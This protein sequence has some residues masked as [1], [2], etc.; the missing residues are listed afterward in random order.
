MGVNILLHVLKLKNFIFVGLSSSEGV[1]GQMYA[2]VECV[3]HILMC[4]YEIFYD[5]HT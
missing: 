2:N 1:G 4:I 5:S 3:M